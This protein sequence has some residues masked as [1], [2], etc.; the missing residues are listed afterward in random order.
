ME[1]FADFL[2]LAQAQVEQET[3]FR[4]QRIRHQARTG[5]GRANCIDCGTPIPAEHR[6]H[7]PNAER[8][9]H[10]QDL[11]ERTR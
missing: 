11:W 4:V 2:D 6:K 5:A 7:T 3:A 8:C 1:R 10:C 9:I